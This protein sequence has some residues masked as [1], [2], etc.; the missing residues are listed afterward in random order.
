MTDTNYNM[1]QMARRDYF[2][3]P[4]HMRRQADWPMVLTVRGGHETFV[5]VLMLE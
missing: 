2:A 4:P 3:L 5:R 1:V